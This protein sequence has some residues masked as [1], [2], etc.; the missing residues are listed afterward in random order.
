MAAR[1]LII[2]PRDGDLVAGAH[3]R[4]IWIVDDISPLRQ[5]TSEVGAR[6][7]HVFQNTVATKWLDRTNYANRGSLHFSGENP[8]SGAAINFWLAGAPAGAVTMEVT[9]L[10]GGRARSWQASARQGIKRSLGPR[11]GHA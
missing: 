3:G 5:L 6:P 4:S 9:D 7:V 10:V 2:H 8:S 1:D 11:V